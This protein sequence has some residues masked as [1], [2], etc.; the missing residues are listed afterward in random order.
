M[1]QPTHPTDAAT[2]EHLNAAGREVLRDLVPKLRD[3]A[4]WA[5]P[6]RKLFP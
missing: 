5:A 2:A 6:Q 4:P 1:A 3:V